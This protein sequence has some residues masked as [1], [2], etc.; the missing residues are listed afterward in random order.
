MGERWVAVM[1]GLVA[2]AAAACTRVDAG[3]AGAVAGG[4][5]DGREPDIP[6]AHLG[7]RAHVGRGHAELRHG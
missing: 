5:P 6:G 4:G 1:C 2:F 3:N 7:G